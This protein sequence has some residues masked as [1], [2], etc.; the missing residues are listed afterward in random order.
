[1]TGRIGTIRV[2]KMGHLGSDPMHG[3]YVIAR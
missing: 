2:A 3:R 1:M